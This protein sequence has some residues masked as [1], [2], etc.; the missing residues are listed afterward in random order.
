MN[1]M[2]PLLVLG[3]TYFTSFLKVLQKPIR[4]VLTIED[5]QYK[6]GSI[7][8]ENRG[9]IIETLTIL[10]VGSKIENKFVIITSIMVDCYEGFLV[11]LIL[12]R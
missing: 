4:K 6:V 7:K 12:P 2:T 3:K 11:N 8:I 10:K 5:F 9:K 1:T